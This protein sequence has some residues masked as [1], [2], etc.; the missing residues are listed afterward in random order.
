VIESWRHHYEKQMGHPCPAVG[1]SVAERV[2][3][4]YGAD[5]ARAVK[6]FWTSE[7]LAWVNYLR[8]EWLAN[9]ENQPYVLAV[10]KPRQQGGR[11]EYTKPRS[12][13]PT[14]TRKR[15]GL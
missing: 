5:A 3:E 6:A 13:T 2:V 11:A 8:L 1:R 14:V 15:K 12:S 7:K 4:I 9:D 10:I